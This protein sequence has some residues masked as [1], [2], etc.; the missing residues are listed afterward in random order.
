MNPRFNLQYLLKLPNFHLN[1]VFEIKKHV[2]KWKLMFDEM[3][4]GLDN[5]E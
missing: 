1:F 4:E 5:D 3:M 2:I